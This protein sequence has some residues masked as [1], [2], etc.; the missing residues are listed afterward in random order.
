MSW[1]KKNKNTKARI[2]NFNSLAI[3]IDSE[4]FSNQTGLC[5][6]NIHCNSVLVTI[7]ILHREW[8]ITFH[9]F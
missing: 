5:V 2:S 9:N 4:F 6:Q 8:Q 3:Y 1:Q 7:I